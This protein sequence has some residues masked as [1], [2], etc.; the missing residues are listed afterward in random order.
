MWSSNE[1]VLIFVAGRT[2]HSQN[3]F[4]STM[5]P[6]FAHGGLDLLANGDGAD[7]IGLRDIY[8]RSAFR[9]PPGN[10]GF[11]GCLAEKGGKCEDGVVCDSDLNNGQDTRSRRAGPDCRKGARKMLKCMEG[12]VIP[13]NPRVI[14]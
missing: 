11:G 7:R 3:K 8:C 5:H 10:H 6:S 14:D 9:K 4:G 13:E 12:D 2:K 1:Q